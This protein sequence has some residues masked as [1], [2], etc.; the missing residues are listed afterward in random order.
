MAKPGLKLTVLISNVI[1]FPDAFQ[2]VITSGSLSLK[3]IVRVQ[4]INS[5]KESESMN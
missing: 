5:S 1:S 3:D 4:N 2:T